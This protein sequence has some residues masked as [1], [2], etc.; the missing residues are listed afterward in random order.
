MRLVWIREPVEPAFVR[1]GNQTV[2]EIIGAVRSDTQRKRRTR[3]HDRY[4]EDPWFFRHV[5]FIRRIEPLE[6]LEWVR[7][8]DHRE[9]QL[10]HENRVAIVVGPEAVTEIGTG[11]A[12][13]GRL[14]GVAEFGGRY[15]RGAWKAGEGASAVAVAAGVFALEAKPDGVVGVGP[16]GW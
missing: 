3:T 15:Q 13:P 9:V 16:C 11:V 5:S 10:D 8:I 4:R 2:P 6:P 1:P 14:E 7:A 12:R